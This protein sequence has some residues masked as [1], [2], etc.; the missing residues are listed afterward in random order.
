[1]YIILDNRKNY[2]PVM[3][4]PKNKMYTKTPHP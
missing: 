4:N 2:H 1:M 3:Q